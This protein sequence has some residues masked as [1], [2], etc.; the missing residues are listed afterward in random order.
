VR[1]RRSGK[2]LRHYFGW[3]FPQLELTLGIFRMAGKLTQ[4]ALPSLKASAGPNV[5]KVSLKLLNSARTQFN[6][7]RI[8][9][10]R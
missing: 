10:T 7:G 9:A 6:H 4:Q 2:S 8:G 5:L 3:G 1:H